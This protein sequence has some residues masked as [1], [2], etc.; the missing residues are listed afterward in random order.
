MTRQGVLL[1]VFCAACGG[2]PTDPVERP[3]PARVI[4]VGGNFQEGPAGQQLA[5][6]VEVQVLGEDNTPL[7]GIPVVFSPLE[8]SDSAVPAL[9]IT[10]T[11]R[12][13]ALSNWWLAHDV[14]GERALVAQVRDSPAILANFQATV[15]ADYVALVNPVDDFAVVLSGETRGGRL[16]NHVAIG[17]DS[18]IATVPFVPGSAQL[19]AFAPSAP[20]SVA[21]P[22]WTEGRDTVRVTFRPRIRVPLTVWIVSGPFTKRRGD[23]LR[24]MA[25]AQVI[26]DAQGVGFDFDIT[27]VDVTGH[28]NAALVLDH[29]VTGFCASGIHDIIGSTPGQ[30]NVYYVRTIGIVG[31]QYCFALRPGRTTVIGIA[32]LLSRVEWVLA[33]ELG[34]AFGL[35]HVSGLDFGGTNL[36]GDG[37]A[38]IVPPYDLTEGQVFRMHFL[39]GSDLGRVYGLQATDALR[40]CDASEIESGRCLPLTLTVFWDSPQAR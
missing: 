34:H 1:A 25:M 9:D 7:P 20:P 37:T 26:Y 29:E 14:A 24:S 17:R 12:L 35:R 11:H 36:M 38:T 13:V 28:R 30:I 21:E 5:F 3:T 32:D 39:E 23:A 6:P 27:V 22:V 2:D 10:G 19:T 33:H 8:P 31:G 18:V 40:T 16:L 4:I 15:N